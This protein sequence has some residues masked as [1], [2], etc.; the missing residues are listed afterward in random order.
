MDIQTINTPEKLH[1]AIGQ[2]LQS[3]YSH[4]TLVK[5][6]DDARKCAFGFRGVYSALPALPACKEN[7]LDGLQDVMDW[8]NESSK[9]VDDIVSNLEQQTIS[10]TISQFKKLRD[11]ADCVLSLVDNNLKE[12]AQKEARAK[13]EREYKN[14]NEEASKTKKMPLIQQV[15]AVGKLELEAHE[16]LRRETK[17]VVQIYLSK[18]PAFKD[19]LSQLHDKEVNKAVETL[20]KLAGSDTSTGKLLDIYCKLKDIP[21]RRQFEDVGY[22]Y[23]LDDYTDMICGGCNRLYTSIDTVIKTFGEIQTKAEQKKA[24][25]KKASGEKTSKIKEAPQKESDTSHK[26]TLSSIIP[27]LAVY[28]GIKKSVSFE[29]LMSKAQIIARKAT[30]NNISSEMKTKIKSLFLSEYTFA[31]AYMRDFLSGLPNLSRDERNYWHRKLTILYEK[32]KD[33]L[34]ES[35]DDNVPNLQKFHELL[36]EEFN[37]QQGLGFEAGGWCLTVETKQPTQTTSNEKAKSDQER[38]QE[39]IA[40]LKN[41]QK[42]GKTDKDFKVAISTLPPIKELKR[43]L[44]ENEADFKDETKDAID[45]VKYA[46]RDGLGY[47]PALLKDLSR[48]EVTADLEGWLRKQAKTGQLSETPSD[49]KVRDTKNG[50]WSKPLSKSQ[51]MKALGID[52][53]TKFNGFAKQH[54]IKKITR[55]IWQLRLNDLSSREREKLGKA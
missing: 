50:E 7:P 35:L 9:V 12:Q 47:Y 29:A 16:I 41:W 2:F 3:N 30:E 20:N 37:I 51:M 39:I 22:A 18:D 44:N 54:G 46:V 52:S 34:F 17:D 5:M 15:E 10:E 11:F 48:P 8:C 53:L 27:E 49:E 4:E 45:N 38:L 13:V 21:L 43:I 40:A 14:L 32:I 19:K 6:Y 26:V 55:K 42:S 33:L 31:T 1:Q 24:G 23:F 25:D 28:D 36:M